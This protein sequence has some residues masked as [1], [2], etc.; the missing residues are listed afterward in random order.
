[1]S[2]QPL[3]LRLWPY[4]ALAALAVAIFLLFTVDVR[5]PDPRPPGDVADVEA[6]AEREG[7]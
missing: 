4:L 3:H 2:D 5:N 7:R 1:M 6:L